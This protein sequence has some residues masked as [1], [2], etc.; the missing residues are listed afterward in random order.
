M[1]MYC[2]CIRFSYLSLFVLLLQGGYFN[3]VRN[4][5]KSS[6]RLREALMD[7][8]LGVPL[9]VLIAQQRQS[10]IFVEATSC[11]LKLLGKLYDQVKLPALCGCFD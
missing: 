4:T 3:Q 8:A 11:H 5:K 6:Q 9:C 10:V 1:Y 7:S 2:L